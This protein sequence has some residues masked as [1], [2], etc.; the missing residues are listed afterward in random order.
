MNYVAFS[1]IKTGCFLYKQPIFSYFIK[2]LLLNLSINI[3]IDNYIPIEH[4]VV[5]E[6]QD[7]G[8]PDIQRMG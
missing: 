2:V 6:H 8:F 1:E 5:Q 3:L 4:L 7:S